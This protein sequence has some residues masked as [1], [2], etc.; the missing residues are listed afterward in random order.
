MLTVTLAMGLLGYA[1][2]RRNSEYA[3]LLLVAAI[4]GGLAISRGYYWG[5]FARGS[6]YG[7]FTF[8]RMS[9]LATWGAALFV[10]MAIG[11]RSNI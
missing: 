4:L 2:A 3:P 8:N 7:W 10:G 9:A 6:G 1:L 11:R 5:V